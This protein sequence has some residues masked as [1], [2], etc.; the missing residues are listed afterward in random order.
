MKKLL[1][2][3]L[4]LINSCS[5]LS[6]N[7]TKG[8]DMKNLNADFNKLWNYSNPLETREKFLRVLDEK[9]ESESLDYILQLKTQ[10]ARTYSLRAEFEQAH[11]VLDEVEKKLNSDTLIAH[12]RYYLE[13]GR[14][15]NLSLIHI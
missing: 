8:N 5:A 9:K 11:T 13:R 15:Y 6:L 12:V 4:I 10:I 3:F 7:Q 2:S 14:T 1:Y